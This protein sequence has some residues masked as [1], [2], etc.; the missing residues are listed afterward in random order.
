[1]QLTIQNPELIKFITDFGKGKQ[2]AGEEF[3]YQCASRYV[4]VRGR[5]RENAKLRREKYS[6]LEDEVEKLRAQVAAQAAKKSA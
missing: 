4:K 1:M 6:D 2:A 5:Q 3:T